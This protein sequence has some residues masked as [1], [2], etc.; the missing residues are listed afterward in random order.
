MTIC[1]SPW[2]NHAGWLGVK[3][4]VTYI[5]Y[6]DWALWKAVYY[7][8]YF[9]FLQSGTWTPRCLKHFLWPAWNVF[10]MMMILYPQSRTWKSRQPTWIFYYYDDYFGFC[11]AKPEPQGGLPE[12]TRGGKDGGV[13][14]QSTQLGRHGVTSTSR[15]QG[16]W[17]LSCQLATW[18]WWVCSEFQQSVKV[19][20]RKGVGQW[21]CH[22][23]GLENV[24]NWA[25]VVFEGLW[26]WM[27]SCQTLKPMNPVV[28][29]VS[30]T[31]VNFWT[32]KL[33]GP[34]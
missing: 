4:Q 13:A 24:E 22:F 29:K 6:R 5:L 3:H 12:A 8:E 14:R 33:L 21:S 27:C 31:V 28:L 30:E 34:L 18:R 11:R 9:G 17:P 25:E 15:Q 16:E 19:W 1:V 32:E 10:I 2:Y 20:G 23:P 26:I 7:D